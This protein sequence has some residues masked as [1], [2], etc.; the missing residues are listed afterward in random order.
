MCECTCTRVSVGA[1]A[2]C[3]ATDTGGHLF[4]GNTLDG[5]RD[6]GF[7]WGGGWG[8]GGHGRR[9]DPEQSFPCSL[10]LS[11]EAEEL[12]GVMS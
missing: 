12:V 7:F 1:R 4:R 9:E 10:S 2:R 8:A 5:A 11:L 6:V 3:T